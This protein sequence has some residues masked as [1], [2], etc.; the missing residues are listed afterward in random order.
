MDNATEATA[1]ERVQ[2]VMPPPPESVNVTFTPNEIA[3]LY[4]DLSRL[5]S[6]AGGAWYVIF[7]A[8]QQLEQAG[9]DLTV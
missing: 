2:V 3:H 1:R 7:D 8:R 6:N 4:N 5:G 9:C